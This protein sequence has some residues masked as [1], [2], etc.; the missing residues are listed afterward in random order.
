[1]GKI[2]FLGYSMSSLAMRAD[3]NIKIFK[4]KRDNAYIL[5]IETQRH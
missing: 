1:M 3:V 2:Y 4:G 5:R